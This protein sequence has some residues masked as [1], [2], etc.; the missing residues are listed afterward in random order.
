[1]LLIPA[2]DLRDGRCVRL[3]QGSFSQ[4]TSYA[5]DPVEMARSFAGQ[6]ARW[7]H[8]VD[9][10][11]AEGKGKN[12]R[13][14]IQRIRD[15][16]SCGI[17]VGGGV[18]TEADAREL[19]TIG[20]DLVVLGTVL[21]KAPEEVAGWIERLGRRFVAG[22]DARDGRVKVAGWTADGG[23]SDLQIATGPVAAGLRGLI[24]TSIGQDGTLAGPDIERTNT[25]AAAAKIPTILSGGIGSESDIAEVIERADR[26]VV[27]IILG[28]ALYESRVDFAR[29]VSRFPQNPEPRWESPTGS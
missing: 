8:V 10:D 23:A 15:A 18:R 21:V 3:L 9:L 19:L 29:A 4:A 14:V 26:F 2:I 11:A 16:V 17:D 1:M 12:N 13:P 28:K 27:G 20:I 5:R 25:I 24:Y 7:L 6:G 22:I